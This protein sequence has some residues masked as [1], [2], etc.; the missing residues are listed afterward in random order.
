MIAQGLQVLWLCWDRTKTMC[1][2]WNYLQHSPMQRKK[3]KSKK[4]QRKSTYFCIHLCVVD[5]PNNTEV[6]VSRCPIV[7]TFTLLLKHL[8]NSEAHN[9]NT[10]AVFLPSSF[11]H[12][13][14]RLASTWNAAQA[15]V[16]TFCF[17][18]C[19][20]F[21]LDSVWLLKLQSRSISCTR[22]LRTK[23]FSSLLYEK[24]NSGFV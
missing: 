3:T 5:N 17:L 12:S 13:T 23:H 10:A 19:F 24:T 20:S 14:Q 1:Q 18:V 7:N 4:P 21:E 9:R 15:M 11:S 8:H 16:A 6:T 22:P 2:T